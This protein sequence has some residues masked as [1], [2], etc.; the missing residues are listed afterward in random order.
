MIIRVMIDYE[1]NAEKWWSNGGRKL[2]DKYEYARDRYDYLNFDEATAIQF[3]KEAEAIE[4]WNDPDAPPYA[5]FPLLYRTD[6]GDTVWMEN[7]KLMV[8][9]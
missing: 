8:S 3:M 1:N 5:P 7:N 4:G 6:E 2:W 9:K